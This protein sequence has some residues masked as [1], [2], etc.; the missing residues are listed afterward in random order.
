[1]ATAKFKDLVP[2]TITEDTIIPC[3]IA[4]NTRSTTV[5]E[6]RN[7]ATDLDDTDNT[8]AASNA[9]LKN[10]SDKLNGLIVDGG[11]F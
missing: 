9:N 3:S 11:E 1:M 5:Q 2:G 7:M 10:V 6:V 8:K 4:G